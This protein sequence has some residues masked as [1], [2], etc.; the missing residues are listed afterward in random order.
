MRIH[1]YGE[2]ISVCIVGNQ[3]ETGEDVLNLWNP[4]LADKIEVH[5]DKSVADFRLTE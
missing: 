1:V 2:L 3:N 4:A 5:P